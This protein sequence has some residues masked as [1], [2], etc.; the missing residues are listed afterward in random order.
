MGAVHVS[1]SGTVPRG[2]RSAPC[3]SGRAALG[4]R[5][6]PRVPSP[7][8]APRLAKRLGAPP[9]AWLSLGER[10]CTGAIS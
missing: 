10:G 8:P 9:P 4:R 1:S 2:S 7:A 3:A 5:A 6:A